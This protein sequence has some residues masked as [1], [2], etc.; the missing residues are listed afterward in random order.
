MQNLAERPA[1]EPE[2]FDTETRRYY[3]TVTWLAEALPGSMCTPFEYQYRGGELYAN[4]GGGLRNI[5][6]DSIK[7]AR[8]LP[9]YE[10]RRRQLE[11]QEY[12][13]MLAMMRGDRPNTMVVVSDFPPEL[14]YATEDAG[15]YSVSRKQTMLRVLTK[16]P[17]GTLKMYSQSLDG[18]DRRGLEAVYEFMQTQARP[19]ELLGQR[20]FA[21][22]DQVNQ[23]FLAEQLRTVYDRSLQAQ[24]GGQWYAGRRGEKARNTFEFV[25]G[26]EDLLNAYLIKTTQFSGG[27]A[28][29]AL[30]AAMTDRYLGRTGK[31][32]IVRTYGGVAAYEIA[33]H[34]MDRASELAQARG[35]T[36]S[37]CGASLKF[38][39]DH[40]SAQ[41]QL[42][43]AGYG[44]K[45]AA[46]EDKY[47]SLKFKCPKGHEN[48]RP[49]GKLIEKCQVCKCSVRC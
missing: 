27:A 46:G 41:S 26:Q 10:Q 14:M 13:D 2:Q 8:A 25:C 47:G 18:S 7:E 44:S 49:H 24:Y 45:A 16:T 28:D 29:Y 5:F 1:I 30:A 37:G 35:E 20:M 22:I 9:V 19:G 40:Q 21:E 33:L 38:S 6:D 36:F 32:V 12:E 42:E 43:E 39:R 48:T 3:D 17:G 4:D 11:M 34:E 31:P 15:G 23:E